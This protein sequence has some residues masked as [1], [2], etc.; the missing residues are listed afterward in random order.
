MIGEHLT[1]LKAFLRGRTARRRLADMA[2]ERELMGDVYIVQMTYHGQV[3]RLQISI[4]EE[5]DDY[6]AA[7]AARRGTSK[8][9]LI[10]EYVREHAGGDGQ[11]EDPL[12]EFI[13]AIDAEPGDIDEVVYGA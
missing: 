6:L 2:R 10:R 1:G 11:E 3:R 4:D 7:E 8:A 12:A 13:G 5:L 9:A